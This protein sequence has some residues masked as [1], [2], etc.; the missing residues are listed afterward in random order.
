MQREIS[1]SFPYTGKPD[2]MMEANYSGLETYYITEEKLNNGTSRF[3]PMMS[4]S[5]DGDKSWNIEHL[6]KKWH[7]EYSVDYCD[8]YEMAESVIKNNKEFR[9]DLFSYVV[10]TITHTL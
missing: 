10:E 3:Y 4:V 9:S 7:P 6:L 2:P 8:S 5:L 1:V